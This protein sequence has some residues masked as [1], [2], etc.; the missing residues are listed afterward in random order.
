MKMTTL[1]G[2]LITCFILVSLV[3]C[4]GGGG[5]GGS[6]PAQSTK[7]VI[8]LSMAGTL[9][10]GALVY[11]T[12]ATVNLPAGVTVKASPSSANPQVMVTDTGVV[13]ASGQAANAETV[14]ATYLASSTTASTSKVALYVAKSGGFSVGEFAL[15]NC[16]ITAGHFPAAADFTVTDFKTFD[17]NGLTISGL[18]AGLTATIQ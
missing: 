7:A 8:T 12:Q 9:P 1:F 10:A 15:V 11:G 6:A 2:L 14:L 13:S 17:S 16:D 3:A 5:G 18:T 4:G